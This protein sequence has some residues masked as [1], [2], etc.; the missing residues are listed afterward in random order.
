MN[1]ESLV[2]CA[3]ALALSLVAC[4]I[5]FR[6]A[7]MPAEAVRAARAPAAAESLPDIPVGGGFG[8]VPV[9]ELLGYYVEN[10][11]AAP[12]ASGAPAT[13]RRFGGC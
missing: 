4:A 9:V 7:A 3:A 6:F 10:P 1:R 13:T 2:F 12:S 8:M 11:L 5:G